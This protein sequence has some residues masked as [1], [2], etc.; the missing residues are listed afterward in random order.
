MARL[1]IVII[2]LV[3]VVA[4]LWRRKQPP[5]PLIEIHPPNADE[6]RPALRGGEEGQAITD[7]PAESGDS[8]PENE[9]DRY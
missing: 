5:Q 9:K 4:I 2:L 8:I 7:L 6:D 3:I 1:I